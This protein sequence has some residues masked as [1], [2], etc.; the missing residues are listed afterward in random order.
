MSRSRFLHSG[1]LLALLVLFCLTTQWGSGYVVFIE[2]TWKIW[3]AV[4][5][6][7]LVQR[8]ALRYDETFQWLLL[9]RDKTPD[10][11]VILLPPRDYFLEKTGG[12]IPLLGSP[13]SAYSQIY[14][15]VP[16]HWGDTSSRK[17]DLTHLLV[18]EYWSLN[19]V[20]SQ[21]TTGSESD[22]FGLYRWPSG[23]SAPW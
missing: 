15:R 7:P 10:E 13:S 11:S 19:Q 12:N 23:R 18:W 3:R 8:W 4:T 16:V 9:L 2:K 22:Q 20:D 6:L 14:P 1:L 17:D 21:V 5:P